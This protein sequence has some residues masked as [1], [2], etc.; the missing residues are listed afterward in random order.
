CHRIFKVFLIPWGLE[1][2]PFFL[3]GMS[4]TAIGNIIQS[5]EYRYIAGNYKGKFSSEPKLFSLNTSMLPGALPSHYGGLSPASRRFDRLVS[6]IREN[7]PDFVFLSELNRGWGSSMVSA[8]RDRYNHFAIDVGLNAIGMEA[9]FFIAYRGKVVSP[10]E[11]IPFNSPRKGMKSGFFIVESPD[12]Y[13]ICTHMSPNSE[14][15]AALTQILHHI[16]KRCGDKRVVF[17]GDFNFE[18]ESDNH[19]RLLKKG[20]VDQLAK[21]DET[22]TNAL[23]VHM[24]NLEEKVVPESIDYMVVLDRG[25]KKSKLNLQ[26]LTSYRQGDHLHGALSDHKALLG[27]L[28]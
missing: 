5:R 26:L 3:L 25:E 21:E 24:H 23:M 10:L 15:D 17:M 9:C 16:E 8:L 2:I 11:F 1:S 4:L 7:N 14:R 20:F 27:V 19:N 6:T 28:A 13:F 18:R 12:T 22:C